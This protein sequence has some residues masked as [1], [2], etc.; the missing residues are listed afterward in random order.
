M[1]FLVDGS[2]LESIKRFINLI[3]MKKQCQH[4]KFV[5][6]T[7][8]ESYDWM[9]KLTTRNPMRNKQ[10]ITLGKNPFYFCINFK[11]I[12]I[13]LLYKQKITL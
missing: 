4:L 5:D 7:N 10:K 2:L 8:I 11:K 1:C 6:L 3:V 9:R 13:N 12:I